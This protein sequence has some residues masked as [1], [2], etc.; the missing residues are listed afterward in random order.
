VRG[1]RKESPLLGTLEDVYT[2][3]L[4]AGI[5]LHRGPAEEP[6]RGLVYRGR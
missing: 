5:S 1:T 6:G 2:K 3:A 4:E